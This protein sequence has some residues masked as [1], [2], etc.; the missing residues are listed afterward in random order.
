MSTI[1]PLNQVI[2]VAEAIEIWGATDLGQHAPHWAPSGNR[3][4]HAQ[5]AIANRI[6]PME[7]TLRIWWPFDG[8][9]IKGYLPL[10]SNRQSSGEFGWHRWQALNPRQ[11]GQLALDGRFWIRMSEAVDAGLGGMETNV[12]NAKTTELL[13]VP[14][15]PTT[16]L[17]ATVQTNKL[18]ERQQQHGHAWLD[19]RSLF[20]G[21][22][23]NRTEL[24]RAPT[25][26]GAPPNATLENP[27][28]FAR[29]K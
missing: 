19:T 21:S 18:S 6:L 5:F 17:G 4:G 23:L 7:T 12:V 3:K 25:R 13:K 14:L 24:N 8:A 26:W 2:S 28:P 20:D 16:M 1:S 10:I 22:H 27:K 9:L 11:G 15:N 29:A